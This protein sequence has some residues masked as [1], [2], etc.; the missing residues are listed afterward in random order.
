MRLL[1]VLAALLIAIGFCNPARA[2]AEWDNVERVV[3]IGDLEGDYEKF[4]GMLRTA[5]LIDRVG[6]WSGGRT[7]LVQLGDVP[8]R[9]PNSR[10]IMDHLMRLEPQ[11]RRAGGYVHALI[12]N[13]EAMNV[14]GDLRYVHPGE[15]AAFTD[16]RS[17][18]RREQFYNRTLAE[19]RRATPRDQ[20]P[21]FDDAFRAQWESEHPLGFVE[22]RAGWAANGRYGRWIA[23][24]D[25]VIRINDTLYVHGGLGP[26]F[27]NAPREAM[28][29]AV[30][31]ALRGR[32]ASRYPDILDH[33][34]GPLWYRGLSTN[35]EAAERAHLEALLAF[36][37]VRRIVVGHSK[38]TS[39]VLPRFGGRVLV[40]DIG[41]PRGHR[42]PHAFLIIENGA[43]ITVHRG[44]RVPIEA[45]TPQATCA[46]LA[47]IAA[48]DSNAGPVAQL[49]A[50]QCA[51]AAAN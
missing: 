17:A 16:A 4:A 24:H 33:Q 48:L 21:A 28:N 3:A 7:H 12:G 25:S 8:D 19:L 27:A 5:G 31:S 45:G 51:P 9:G 6:N 11:A 40:A 10:M 18:R 39:T 13:H 30:R 43:P 42:D 50:Q 47:R 44:Q 2:Q 32:P 1:S 35:P 37:G 29:Q 36:H 26:S 14:T 15:Y 49:T 34:E 41:V 46:Y 22:H 20:L 38:V 23:G